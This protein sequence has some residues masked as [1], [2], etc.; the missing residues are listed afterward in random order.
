MYQI[1]MVVCQASHDDLG[2]LGAV[3]MRQVRHVDHGDAAEVERSDDGKSCVASHSCDRIAVRE[4]VVLSCIGVAHTGVEDVVSVG[5]V[6][7]A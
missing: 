4:F 6:A 1:W 2:E 7:A 3:D 5:N